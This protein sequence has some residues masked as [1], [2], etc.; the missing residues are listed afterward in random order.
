MVAKLCHCAAFSNINDKL[1][2]AGAPGR[3]L[4]GADSDIAGRQPAARCSVESPVL[5]EYKAIVSKAAE[6]AEGS[7]WI[8][9]RNTGWV[10]GPLGPSM[11]RIPQISSS[12]GPRL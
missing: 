1:P 2:L 10:E 4:A 3:D 6:T 5:G 7:A 8:D 11:L 9:S 12:L